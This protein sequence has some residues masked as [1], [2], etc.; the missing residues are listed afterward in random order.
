MKNYVSHIAFF[1]ISLAILTSCGSSRSTL[2]KTAESQS[3]T[4]DDYRNSA[5]F[6]EAKRLFWKGE[7]EG[8]LNAYEQIIKNNP[9][10][11]AAYYE[12]SK[13]LRQKEP[14]KALDFGEKAFR[15][16]PDNSWIM[17][18]LSQL[19]VENKEYKKSLEICEAL[20][21]KFPDD[22]INYYRLVNANLRLGNLNKSIKAYN[23]I[24]STFGE[25]PEIALKRKDLYLKTGKTKEAIAEMEKLIQKY[26]D[27]ERYYGIIADIFIRDG[28][29]E[30][31]IEFYNKVLEINPEDEKIH[32]VL[33]SWYA[34]Q[35]Q[36]ERSYN[37]TKKAMQSKGL[38]VDEKIEIMV[39]M[40]DLLD[41]YPANDKLRKQ[42]D[43]L[44]GL[45]VETHPTD[46]KSMTMRADY[47]VRD[48]NYAEAL[49]LYQQVISID[50]TRY[51]IWKQVVLLSRDLKDYQTMQS[52]ARRAMELFPQQAEMYYFNGLSQYKIKNFAEA[53]AS[54]NLGLSFVYKNEQKVE[55]YT[56]MGM[57]RDSLQR[58]QEAEVSFEKA[59]M[60]DPNNGEALNAYAKHLFF[61]KKDKERAYNLAKNAIELNL[62]N[63]HYIA[64]LA[65]FYL[66]DNQLKEAKYWIE[67][68]QN[69]DSSNR[70]IIH[71]NNL[72]K[73][74][75]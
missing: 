16:A 4:E 55:I 21:E 72:L 22:Q 51:P 35:N 10:H 3:V 38:N 5:V 42:S 54:L 68:G 44:L 26:P 2:T 69:I 48:S 29:T 63:V 59:L 47:L 36:P 34:S 1:L 73:S 65:E 14:S 15:L 50:S 64:T 32:V 75:D 18:N 45:L 17:I 13:L 57:I 43:T 67:K 71:L 52:Y 60:A 31:A 6:I 33:A 70:V 24:E 37:E 28:Q 12:L 40:Y 62:G 74:K 27:N 56:L 25:N 30:K 66:I 46:P 49:Q 53:E 8:A 61:V 41:K 9:K 11:F 23:L 58:N 19:Y 20:V 7:Y 39:K